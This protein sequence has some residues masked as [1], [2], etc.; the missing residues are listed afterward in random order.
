MLFVVALF[1][2][3][4]VAGLGAFIVPWAVYSLLESAG[5]VTLGRAGAK[6]A[7][8]ATLNVPG[9]IGIAALL[10]P[11]QG[12]AAF[13]LLPI[14]R[15]LLLLLVA[16]AL[17]AAI[18]FKRYRQVAK[19]EYSFTA[20]YTTPS[21]ESARQVA[22]EDKLTRIVRPETRRHGLRIE[23]VSSSNELVCRE[24]GALNPIDARV[25]IECGKRPYMDGP[26][27][28]CPVCSAPLVYATRLDVDRLL[29]GVCFA[30][31]VIV[32]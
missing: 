22:S 24:C 5:Y 31:L 19:E 20:F 3:S 10:L 4:G 29:C 28:K 11:T 12:A 16:S 13:L 9:V 2:L 8:A 18:S 26:G 27:A 14:I 1:S 21:P 23:V 15:A 25:C 7:Y 17:I 6:L 32:R 30:E